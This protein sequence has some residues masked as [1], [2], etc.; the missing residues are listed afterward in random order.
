MDIKKIWSGKLAIGECP[1]WHPTEKVLY[2]IDIAERMLYRLDPQTLGLEKWSLPYFIGT[3]V[4]RKKG[5][6]VATIGQDAV[7]I[8]M[9]SGKIEKLAQIIPDNRP[10][11]RM[12]DGKCDSLGR[13]WIGVAN[14]NLEDPQGGLFRLDPDGTVTQM[15]SKITISNGMGVS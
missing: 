10:D 4:P 15:E 5:G 6:L 11:L 1:M 8:E 9:P 14:L 2:F 12:N 13:F 7:I 3:V